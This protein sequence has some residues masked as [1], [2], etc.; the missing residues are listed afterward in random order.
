M[1]YLFKTIFSLFI[2]LFAAGAQASP[3]LPLTLSL[4]PNQSSVNLGSPLSVDVVISSID[5]FDFTLG[6]FDIDLAYDT[7]IL[8][9]TGIDFGTALGD[10]SIGESLTDTSASTPGHVNLTQLSLLESSP[11]N[12]GFCQAPYLQ[13][14]QGNSF[15]LVS[16][17]FDTVGTGNA[18]FGLS[19]NVLSDGDA[20]ELGANIA[21]NPAQVASVPLPAAV[22]LF[23]SMLP[24]IGWK[25]KPV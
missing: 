12:C 1:N 25:R 20:N 6:G 10:E 18:G 14:L 7:S 11:A 2:V 4:I 22:W 17:D 5:N 13:D 21:V 19:I 16:L 24:L 9:L 3:V 15:I 8:N 23:A